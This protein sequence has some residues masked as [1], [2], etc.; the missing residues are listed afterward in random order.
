MNYD[1]VAWST[2]IPDTF[3]G[4]GSVKHLPAVT[5]NGYHTRINDGVCAVRAEEL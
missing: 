5:K 1:I 2:F 3:L 4:N